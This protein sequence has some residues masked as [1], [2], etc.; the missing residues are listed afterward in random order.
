Q[1]N[2][3]T[4]CKRRR[5]GLRDPTVAITQRPPW[6]RQLHAMCLPGLVSAL[7]AQRLRTG[8]SALLEGLIRIELAGHDSAEVC[9]LP[10]RIEATGVPRFA[11]FLHV[12]VDLLLYK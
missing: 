10:L 6:A 11:D 8:I 3:R 9:R 12:L 1:P 5:P 4:I 7:K 2:G